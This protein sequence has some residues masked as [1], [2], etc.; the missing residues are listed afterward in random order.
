MPSIFCDRMYLH[1]PL[2]M[3]KLAWSLAAGCW[4]RPF[5]VTASFS[6]SLEGRVFDDAEAGKLA[7]SANIGFESVRLAHHCMVA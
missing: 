6:A 4:R 5:P 3:L 2:I 7:S 1:L